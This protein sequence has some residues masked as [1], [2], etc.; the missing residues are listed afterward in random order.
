MIAIFNQKFDNE[1][2][3]SDFVHTETQDGKSLLDAHFAT[4]NRHLLNF[5]K[6]WRDN[7]V[8]RINTSKGLAYALSFGQGMK[9]SIVLLV[10]FNRIKLD[11]LKLLFNKMI[12]QCSEY[13]TIGQII[14]NLMSRP[15]ACGAT[16]GIKTSFN[17]LKGVCFILKY[18]RTQT[19]NHLSNFMLIWLKESSQ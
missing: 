7:H 10:E 18:M 16:K 13:Y 19:S 12:L 3:I 5:M 1:F 4:S 11:Q 2:F 15:K 17:K 9:N 14:L 6:T 8:T